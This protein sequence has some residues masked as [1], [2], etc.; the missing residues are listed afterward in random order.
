MEVHVEI[1]GDVVIY[2][3]GEDADLAEYVAEV[4]ERIEQAEAS[5]V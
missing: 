1:D 4:C 2:N 3:V 5:V